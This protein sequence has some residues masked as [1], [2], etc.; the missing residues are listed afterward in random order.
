MR[1]S[2]VFNMQ[3]QEFVQNASFALSQQNFFI[4]ERSIINGT[5]AD[6]LSLFSSDKRNT[7]HNLYYIM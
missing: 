2:L 7:T 4:E 1:Y 6:D 5:N 3:T